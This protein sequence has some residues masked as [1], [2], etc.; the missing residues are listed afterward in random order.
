M[1]PTLINVL[2][3]PTTLIMLMNLVSQ[4]P[5]LVDKTKSGSILFILN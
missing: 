2:M 4:E 3:P 1:I 5:P